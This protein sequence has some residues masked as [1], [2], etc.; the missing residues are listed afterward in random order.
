MQ[1]RRFLSANLEQADFGNGPVKVPRLSTVAI[2]RHVVASAEVGA[3]LVVAADSAVAHHKYMFVD[4]IT[5]GERRRHTTSL[6][7]AIL[8]Y[9]DAVH[10]AA[11]RLELLGL[12][13]TCP[14]LADQLHVVRTAHQT[15]LARFMPRNEEWWG[16]HLREIE[17]AFACLIKE[18]QHLRLLVDGAVA[19]YN[20]YTRES[21]RLVAR[22]GVGVDSDEL[23]VAAALACTNVHDFDGC[24]LALR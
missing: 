19:A 7:A 4:S 18:A 13:D 3:R 1:A 21:R 14:G 23:D 24:A 16:N 15:L 11:G 6:T 9:T 12:V 5:I 22:R 20:A 17:R 8:W 2:P 10:E